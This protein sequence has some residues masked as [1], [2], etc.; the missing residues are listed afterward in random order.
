M[1][2]AFEGLR[3]CKSYLRAV[4]TG[5]ANPMQ[6]LTADLKDRMRGR[7]LER[8]WLIWRTPTRTTT[9]WPLIILGLRPL[10]LEMSIYMPTIVP[11]YFHLDMSKHVMRNVSRLCLRAHTLKVEAAAWL[12]DGRTPNCWQ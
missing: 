3:G 2:S 4:Q 7:C 10:F 9:N 5:R 12:E 1:L 11:Q 8:G 6:E